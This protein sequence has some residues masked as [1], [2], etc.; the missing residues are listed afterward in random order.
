[1]TVASAQQGLLAGLRFA[2]F[3]GSSVFGRFAW[4]VT[5]PVRAGF[6]W[7]V[8]NAHGQNG[9]GNAIPMGLHLIPPGFGPSILGNADDPFFVTPLNFAPTR[10]SVRI[11]S[12]GGS[13]ND[14]DS[15]QNTSIVLNPAGPF[16]VPPGWALMLWEEGVPA[17]SG[18]P[19]FIEMRLGYL[20]L[21]VGVEAPKIF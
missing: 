17:P 15:Q 9:N 1:M 12:P 5:P 2:T 14:T 18:T 7:W 6:Y 11:T 3:R 4:A 16:I 21:A 10:A 8:A 19:H 20:E 13:P